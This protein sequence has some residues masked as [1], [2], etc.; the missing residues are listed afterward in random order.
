MP[1]QNAR[2]R[3]EKLRRIRGES[4]ITMLHVSAAWVMKASQ[5]DGG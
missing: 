1:L 3:V 4:C 2:K 5:E